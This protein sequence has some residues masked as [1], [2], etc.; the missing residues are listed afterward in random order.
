MAIL[1]L[2]CIETLQINNWLID[3]VNYPDTF[4]LSLF[5]V[6]FHA[7]NFMPGEF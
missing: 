6:N 1:G 4:S 7:F 2:A 3:C 5:T